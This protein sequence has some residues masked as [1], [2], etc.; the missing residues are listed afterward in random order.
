ME[1]V[2][3]LR[4][5]V[6]LRRFYSWLLFLY[7]NCWWWRQ[8]F[9]CCNVGGLTV[10][11]TDCAKFMSCALISFYYVRFLRY[12]D[13]FLSG[14]MASHTWRQHSFLVL[15]G[16]QFLIYTSYLCMG[17]ALISLNYSRFLRY[18]DKFLSDHTVSH[19]IR[20]HSFLVLWGWQFLIYTSYLCMGCALISLNY[21]RFLRYVD[22]FLSDYTASHTIRQHSF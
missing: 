17:C 8:L 14:H 2:I 21:S 3:W 22:K 16:W 11:T 20:K 5:S 15:W 10:L 4:M 18:V 19:T 7:R 13:K 12:V 9:V 1:W 6:R